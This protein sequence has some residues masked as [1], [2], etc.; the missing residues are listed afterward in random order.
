MR[1]MWL[2]P[3]MRLIPNRVWALERPC[4]AASWRWW[5]RNEGL[6]AKNTENAAHRE[7]G[8]AEVSHGVGAVVAPARV[9]EALAAAPHG[10]DQAVEHLHGAV[11]SDLTAR[12]QPSSR[13][14]IRPFRSH[15]P[16]SGQKENCWPATFYV[17]KTS[18]FVTTDWEPSR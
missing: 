12:H 17:S 16:R 15:S 5:A 4:P 3:G 1:R 11:E 8:Q 14:P 7:R 9:G 18:V 2:S 10:T 6:W 13:C